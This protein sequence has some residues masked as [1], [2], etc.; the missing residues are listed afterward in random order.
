MNSRRRVAHLAGLV[1]LAIVT[2]GAGCTSAD[3]D[4][5]EGVTDPGVEHV[6]GLGID[7]AD[8]TL[9][10][11]THSGLFR[12][13]DGGDPQR[14]GD[15]RQDTMG[16][17]VLGANQFLGSGHP[18]PRDEELP[19]LLGLIESTDAGRE[20][21]PVSL[22]GEADFHA[23]VAR[24]GHVYGYDATNGRLMV[25]SDRTT[26]DERSSPPGLISLAVD[27]SDPDG[28]LATTTAG[29]ITSVDGGRS[30]SE[31][32]SAPLVL[33]SWADDGTLAAAAPEGS[34]YRS[35]DRGASWTAVGTLPGP[36]EALLA[37]DDQTLV[38]AV[39]ADGIYLSSD[40]GATWTSAS[41]DTGP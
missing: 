34:I 1:A 38:A 25:S 19:P 29:L 30:W 5:Q 11:A 41:G 21:A 37:I 22:L 4:A 9:Y 6:H 40:G 23:L 17:T 15:S 8:G 26:W 18:D 16:F 3:D 13:P 10:A 31:A 32:S 14:V 12:I 7:P 39:A 27:P 24:H 28:L 35:P 2:F 20:W 33:V 36:P